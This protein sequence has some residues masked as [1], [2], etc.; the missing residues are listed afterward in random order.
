VLPIR[1]GQINAKNGGGAG[2]RHVQFPRGFALGL[3]PV[4]RFQSQKHNDSGK[5]NAEWISNGC[6]C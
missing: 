5:H 4:P 1:I 2:W 3:F 6:W